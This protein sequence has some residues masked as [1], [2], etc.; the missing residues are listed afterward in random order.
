M[1]GL[2]PRIDIT[3][4]FPI[5]IFA[6]KSVGLNGFFS[7]RDGSLVDLGMTTDTATANIPSELDLAFMIDATSSMSSYIHSAQEVCARVNKR[8]QQ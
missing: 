6:Y 1:G 3:S 8:C 7:R 4:L 5:K 2:C